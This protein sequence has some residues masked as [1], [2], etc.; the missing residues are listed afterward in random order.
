M[1]LDYSRVVNTLTKHECN[2]TVRISVHVI[3]PIS[4]PREENKMEHN[5]CHFL[6][7]FQVRMLADAGGELAR[8][9]TTVDGRYGV[10]LEFRNK[11]TGM[12]V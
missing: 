1:Y 5:A 9:S 8:V 4:S 11:Q 10:K 3:F 7:H 12:T 2:K 6:L